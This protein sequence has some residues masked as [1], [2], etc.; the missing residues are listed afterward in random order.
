MST[1][2]M[3]E[4]LPGG[5]G[6]RGSCGLSRLRFVLEGAERDLRRVKDVAALLRG[7]GADEYAVGRAGDEV[8]DAF[9]A[10]KK[11]HGVAVSLV[12]FVGREDFVHAVGVAIHD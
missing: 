10:A 4:R 11:G 3:E 12:R 5:E 6:G 2:G 7:D 1:S 8:A 9:V